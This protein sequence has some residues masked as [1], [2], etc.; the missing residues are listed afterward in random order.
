MSKTKKKQFG[1]KNIV[2][3]VVVMVII[4]I[5]CFVVYKIKR[6][7]EGTARRLAIEYLTKKYGNGDWK[8][9]DVRRDTGSTLNGFVR[10]D[11]DNGYIFT[12]TS[13]YTNDASFIVDVDDTKIITTDEFLPTYYSLKYGFDY[14][15]DK[16]MENS[17]SFEEL[18][19]RMVYI[20][21]YHYPYNDYKYS[22]SG[23]IL[24]RPYAKI[25]KYEMGSFYDPISVQRSPKTEKVL[26]IIPDGGNIPEIS[27]IIDAVEQYYS[28]GLM[29]NKDNHDAEL[30]KLVF[31]DKASEEEVKNFIKSHIAPVDGYEPYWKY[32]K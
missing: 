30:Y 20:S 21:D 26:D 32:T 9:V 11:Y 25:F 6:P 1:Y 27:T 14:K 10:S 8:I 29:R 19:K 22:S 5:S 18:I 13:S 24:Q 2:I 3:A 28:S 23:P 4:A 31:E 16:Y 7:S 12:V 15:P 17:A